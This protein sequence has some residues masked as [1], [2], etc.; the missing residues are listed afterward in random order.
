MKYVDRQQKGIIMVSVLL[1]TALLGTIIS[2]ALIITELE[3]ST[4]AANTKSSRCLYIAEAGIEEAVKCLR[5]YQGWNPA[6]ATPTDDFVDKPLEDA[7]GNIIGYYTV[8]RGTLTDS[9]PPWVI[10]PVTSV[11][12]LKAGCNQYSRTINA[13]VLTAD[14]GNFF[15]YTPSA[16]KIPG[17]TTITDGIIFG[18][19]LEFT[20][21]PANPSSSINVTGDGSKVYYTR[22]CIPLVQPFRKG[23]NIPVPEYHDPVTF[24]AIN[25]QRYRDLA[26]PN[27]D[28]SGQGYHSGDAS[29]NGTLSLNQSTNGVIFVE[30]DALIDGDLEVENPIIIVAGGDISIKGDITWLENGKLG[31]FA[32]NNVYI[33]KDAPSDELTIYAQVL[34][35]GGY[36][37]AIGIPLY[38]G[39]LNFTGSMILRGGDSANGAADLAVYK[40]RN[41]TYQDI[42]GLPYTT[43]IANISSWEDV[44]GVSD[45]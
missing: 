42:T 22:N 11:G 13:Q 45:E 16:F 3:L 19:E 12:R 38:K 29:F 36:F 10:V 28:G 39:T 23:I 20:I 32:K 4:S 5:E 37:N 21:D 26:D 27:G 30:G 2:S 8:T 25:T 14:P 9:S 44:G 33:H 40:D 24:P 34:A 41:Y 7:S 17:G 31:L 35:E 1:M 15:A 43:Y 6:T 18:D